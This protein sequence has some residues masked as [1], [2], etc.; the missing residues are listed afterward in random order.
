MYIRDGS[1]ENNKI[2]N[3]Q[4]YTENKSRC[5]EIYMYVTFELY[6]TRNTE[7][8]YLVFRVRKIHRIR[9]NCILHQWIDIRE[10]KY[11][12][13]HENTHTHTRAHQIWNSILSDFIILTRINVFKRNH[14]RKKHRIIKKK[15]ISLMFI[16]H[17]EID[18]EET[19]N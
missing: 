6:G 3:L 4:Y 11:K 2:S 5:F 14:S 19:I 7:R 1:I 18:E 17:R 13:F 9:P 15:L 12:A 16:K 10:N 8:W